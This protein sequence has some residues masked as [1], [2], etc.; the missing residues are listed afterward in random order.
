[1]I[2]QGGAGDRDGASALRWGLAVVGR[3]SGSWTIGDARRR[4]FIDLADR[5]RRAAQMWAGARRS[6]RTMAASGRGRS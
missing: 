1:M 2:L 5:A 6:A 4:D 3:W